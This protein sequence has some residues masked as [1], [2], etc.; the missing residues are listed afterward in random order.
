MEVNPP[1]WG[2]TRQG[3]GA[4][5]GEDAAG[6]FLRGCTQQAGCTLRCCWPSE[7]EL[8]VVACTHKH[9][10]DERYLLSD[11]PLCW[12]KPWSD[13]TII[14]KKGLPCYLM[15]TFVCT[16]A[17]VIFKI[18]LG[19]F[20]KW[21]RCWSFPRWFKNSILMDM[22]QHSLFVDLNRNPWCNSTWDSVGGWGGGGNQ[23]TALAVRYSLRSLHTCQ[24]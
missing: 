12:Q 8:V 19:L 3:G 1:K 7:L 24:P 2:T 4:T 20:L 17:E 15:H 22:V 21:A 6:Q 18:S 5:L 11:R 16:C 14:S 9:L 23:Y 13:E 10:N